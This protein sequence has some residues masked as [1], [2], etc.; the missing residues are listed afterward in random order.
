MEMLFLIFVIIG[1]GILIANHNA[2]IGLFWLFTAILMILFPPIALA[3]AGL[4][5]YVTITKKGGSDS[6][7]AYEKRKA[8]SNYE[9]SQQRKGLP[10]DPNKYKPAKPDY[11]ALPWAIHPEEPYDLEVT[12]GYNNWQS[13]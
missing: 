8:Q 7:D 6:A 10:A 3:V 1:A 11:D 9:R 4:Y 5:F 12:Y 13:E 2:G